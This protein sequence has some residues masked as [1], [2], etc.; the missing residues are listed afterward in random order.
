[1]SRGPSTLVIAEAGVNHNGSVDLALE[2]IDAAAE[3]GADAVKFQT[4]RAD[5]LATPDAPK[6]RYQ[7]ETTARRET[8]YEMLKSLELSE[9]QYHALVERCRA[10]NIRFLSTPF[11]PQSLSFLV[12]QLAADQIKLPSGEITNGPLLLAAAR[13]GLPILLSTGMSTLE[14]VEQALGVMAFGYTVG[15]RPPSRRAFTEAFAS[16]A[17]AEAVRER[18]TLLHCT[19]AYPA[20]LHTIHLRAMDTLASTFGLPVG[21]SDHS[22]GIFVA[23]A[24]VARGAAV[25]EKHFTMDRSLPGPDHRASLEPGELAEMVAGIRAV[26]EALGDP[27][28]RPAPEEME[29]REVVRKSLSAARALEAGEELM[30]EDLVPRRPGTG[31]SPMEYWDRVG[32]SAGRAYR[33]N[34]LLDP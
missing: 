29:N 32:S 21:Y 23:I 7:L 1:M 24:A 6:A 9:E 2:L 12:E 10:R 13:T 18:V 25:V 16:D 30:P 27:T 17:G 22:Q 8:Q 11:D 4:F 33:Q 15:D 34:E 28:K 26:E 3:A 20:P 19:T 31:L 14:E 5:A